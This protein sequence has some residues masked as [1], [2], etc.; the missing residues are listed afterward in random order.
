MDFITTCGTYLLYESTP[1]PF[2]PWGE[3]LSPK[4]YGDYLEAAH[5]F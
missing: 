2:Y 1:T 5:F 3:M 4:K